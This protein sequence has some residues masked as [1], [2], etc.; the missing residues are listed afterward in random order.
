VPGGGPAPW[1]TNP[2][3]VASVMVWIGLVLAVDAVPVGAHLEI[4]RQV[5]LGIGTWIV[6]AAIL[7]GQPAMV[8]A[9]TG[10]VVVLATLVEYTFSPLLEVYVYR[11]G[12]VPPFV[13]PGHGLVYLA[14]MAIGQLGFVRRFA[15]LAVTVTVTLGGGWALAGLL[16][17]RRDVL[18]A[19][20][21]L[22]LLGFL[23]WGRSRLLYV[24]AFVVVGL[25]ELAG[26]TLGTWTWAEVDP[27]LGVIGQGN[28]P[29]GVAG[30]YG[31]FD[32]YALLL[33][34]RLLGLRMAR[35]F[36][37]SNPLVAKAFPPEQPSTPSSEENRPPA[38]VTMGT[39]A[40]MS[41][42]ANSGSVAMSTA[43]SATS[44][45]DQKSP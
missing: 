20:W 4:A 28:P 45:Y 41:Y 24:G 7:A 5:V 10:V 44:M 15:R 33:A 11:I 12:T 18:G 40:A 37:W 23:R 36:S 31:W 26:T 29:S 21:F 22:C 35:T 6:L 34:P 25:L 27:L 13:P 43:P 39:S 32:L 2:G 30:G 1:R 19:F 42:N 38:S 3:L 17:P 9:Q 16:G 14:A 8:R